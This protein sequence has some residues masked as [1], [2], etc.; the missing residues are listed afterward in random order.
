MNDL[1]NRRKAIEEIR[2]FQE[3][4]TCDFSQDYESGVNA[5]LDYAVN[6]IE[7]MGKENAILKDDNFGFA[8]YISKKDETGYHVEESWNLK[9]N[10][11]ELLCVMYGVIQDLVK[12]KRLGDLWMRALDLVK[13]IANEEME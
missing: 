11:E 2:E 13:F 6:V 7:L 9:L 10:D 12:H 4:V 1:I 8:A 3:Q 5:G